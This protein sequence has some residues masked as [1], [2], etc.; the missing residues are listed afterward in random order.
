MLES[1]RGVAAPDRAQA[2]LPQQDVI[3][4]GLPKGLQTGDVVAG[5]YRIERV[6]GSG[7]MGV[8]VAA[9]HLNLDRTVAIKF[10]LGE[11]MHHPDAVARF[12]RE[13]RAAARICSTHVVR[14]HDVAVLPD[15][16]PYIELEYLEGSDLAARLRECVRLPVAL[17]VDFILQACDAIG[18]AHELGIIHRDLK[19]ANLFAVRSHGDA[20]TIK[21]LDFGI[22]KAAASIWS[23]M[24]PFDCQP[25]AITTDHGPIG[26]PCYMSPEQMESARDVDLRTDVWSLGVT[27]CEL[28]T[29]ELPFQ[30]QSMVELYA[31][32]KSQQPLRLRRRC[33][34]LPEALEAALLKCLKVD[35]EFRFASV[36]ALA[37]VLLPYGSNRAASYVQR[38]AAVPEH[39][40]PPGASPRGTP[41]PLPSADEPLK[42]TRLSPGS[43][44]VAPAASWFYRRAAFAAVPLALGVAAVAAK[45]IG[46]ETARD[47]AE[48]SV[49]AGPAAAAKIVTPAPAVDGVPG[50]SAAPTADTADEGAT[51]SPPSSNAD[52]SKA[53]RVSASAPRRSAAP[54]ADSSLSRPPAMIVPRS[55]ARDGV[56]AIASPPPSVADRSE[57]QGPSRRASETASR[58]GSDT[59]LATSASTGAPS[60]TVLS[61][62]APSTPM[63]PSIEEMLRKRE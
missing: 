32:I 51:R 45:T 13:A 20:E 57:L 9:H 50:S 30:G 6:L 49:Q 60:A 54:P 19:P 3:V 43:E 62:P 11:A 38:I 2:L 8:V 28:V 16:I 29:G 22:S 5:K 53:S 34:D 21:V 18:E 44:P 37:T 61:G 33:P 46:N 42:E 17:A 55:P 25:R 1:R 52:A 36:D 47:S 15:G 24:S 4:V 58:I 23:T 39:R 12:V 41:V 7:A 59:A 56:D 35:R 10:L 27:L 48:V 26:S 40:G 14:V 31:T 63:D